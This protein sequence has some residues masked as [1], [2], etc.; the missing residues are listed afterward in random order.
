M[1]LGAKRLSG[2]RLF[3]EGGVV[4]GAKRLGCWGETTKVE[5]RGE[6]TWEERTWGETSWGRNDFLPFTLHVFSSNK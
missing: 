6:K 2:K 3:C 4:L 1:V 5:N